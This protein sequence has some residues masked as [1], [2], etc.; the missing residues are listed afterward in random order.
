LSNLESRVDEVAGVV[1]L[2]PG[3][4]GMGGDGKGEAMIHD[5][6]RALK[7][8]VGIIAANVLGEAEGESWNVAAGAEK[9]QEGPTHSNGADGDLNEK[10]DD[11]ASVDGAGNDGDDNHQTDGQQN[12][13]MGE[14]LE[15]EAQQTQEE[16]RSSSDP[17]TLPP[18]MKAR[19]NWTKVRTHRAFLVKKI[20]RQVR[21][22]VLRNARSTNKT[23]AR[24]PNSIRYH[25]IARTDDA[26]LRSRAAL[27]P[28]L[29]L[30][31]GRLLISTNV[32]AN[33]G[34]RCRSER[35][36]SPRL[37]PPGLNVSKR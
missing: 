6:L 24:P 26:F 27:P 21:K 17:R 37:S 22:I 28:G 36:A 8:K 2:A 33:A 10:V 9:E 5:E 14:K 7:K 15:E 19:I 1:H 25:G 3:T 20:R 35:L 31:F 29:T 34:R 12:K 11:T 4:G 16:G 18:R 32:P 30:D 13:P 23:L